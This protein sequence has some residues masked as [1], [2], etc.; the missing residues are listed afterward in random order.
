MELAL[1]SLHSF[2]S[3]LLMQLRMRDEDIRALKADLAAARAVSEAAA[4]RADSEVTAARATAEAAVARAAT[5]VAAAQAAS[6]A[7][8][9]QA[10]TELAARTA[11]RCQEVERVQRL[12]AAYN[13]YV[14]AL[15]TCFCDTRDNLESYYDACGLYEEG[16]RLLRQE[17]LAIHVDISQSESDSF[18]AAAHSTFS[19]ASASCRQLL[20]L[21]RRESTCDS[22][23]VPVDGGLIV[24]KETSAAE[25]HARIAAAREALI[26]SE[27]QLRATAE[28]IAAEIGSSLTYP[29]AAATTTSDNQGGASGFTP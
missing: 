15:Y 19:E 18:F 25:E 1:N 11:S 5:E 29:G 2:K 27:A 16:N 21:E 17:L 24:P 28:A 22:E 13:S 4:V 3:S 26:A 20:W 14:D 10:S 8:A 9:G 23:L 6:Q 12:S 7:A